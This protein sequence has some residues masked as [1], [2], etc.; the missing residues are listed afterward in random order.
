MFKQSDHLQTLDQIK[1]LHQQIQRLETQLDDL[2]TPLIKQ[3]DTADECTQLINS[4]PDCVQRVFAHD[5]RRQLAK[6][7][8]QF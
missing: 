8:Y 5:R 2:A 6:K 4:L 1:R 7:P 3:C